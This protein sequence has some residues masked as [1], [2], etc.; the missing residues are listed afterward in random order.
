MQ[1]ILRIDMTTQ[2]V[3]EQQVAQE[4]LLLG[5]R[6]LTSRYIDQEV[7]PTCHPL[8]KNNKLIFANGPLAG[9]LVSSANRN[10]RKV[11][12]LNSGERASS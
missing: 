6:A 8:G 7:P 12:P 3:T 9:T 10:R 2:Q 4:D 11:R 5:G 1:R